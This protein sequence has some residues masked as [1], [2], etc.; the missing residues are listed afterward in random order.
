MQI[1]TVDD[2]PVFARILKHMLEKA[3]YETLQA[4]NGQEALDIL[5]Q[6]DVRLVITDWEMPKLTGVDLVR[7][8]RSDAFDRYVYA[9]LLTSHSEPEYIVDGMLAGADDFI[10]KPFNGAELRV[11]IKAAER[12]LSLEMRDVAIFMMAKLAESRD[13]E[14]GHH[15]ERVQRYS[16]VLAE[17][18]GRTDKYANVIDSDYLRLIFQTSPLHDIGK[19]GTPDHILLKPGKLTAEEFEVM[20]EHT[21][22]GAKTLDLALQQYPHASFLLMARDIAIAHH[23][24]F[25]GSG[26]PHGL[27]GENIPLAARIVALADVY[28]A[29][30]SVRVYKDAF[31][32]ERTKEVILEGYG[33]HFDPDV[34]DAF[35]RAQDRFSEIKRAYASTLEEAVVC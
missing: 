32:E 1:L 27:I 13:P 21:T 29:L 14:T 18:L 9:I 10:S 3:G 34:V 8:L 6:T 17:E 28:D 35:L 2:D 7:Q 24:K 19:V 30:T 20:K 4:S 5:R 15:L 23:E 25:D 26:Y 12:V 16:R 31:S 22:H 33:K 11:R